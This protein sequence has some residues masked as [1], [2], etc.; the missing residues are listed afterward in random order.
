MIMRLKTKT[1]TPRSPN[2]EKKI[3]TSEID[4]EKMSKLKHVRDLKI[5]N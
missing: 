2:V 1:S 5:M 4:T 3:S